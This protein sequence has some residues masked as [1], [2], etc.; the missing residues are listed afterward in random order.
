MKRG[1]APAMNINGR[2]YKRKT[3][4]VAGGKNVFLFYKEPGAGVISLGG[5][6]SAQ[7]LAV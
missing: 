2:L 7:E 4:S 6:V 3:P 5:V 1:L